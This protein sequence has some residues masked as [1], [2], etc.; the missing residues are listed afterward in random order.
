MMMFIFYSL[1]CWYRVFIGNSPNCRTNN[2]IEL[3]PQSHPSIHKHL[4]GSTMMNPRLCFCRR[5]RLQI[6]KKKNIINHRN[7]ITVAH[8]E[9]SVFDSIPNDSDL[10]DQIKAQIE[11]ATKRAE[12]KTG[13]DRLHFT[14]VKQDAFINV[15]S[16]LGGLLL[17]GLT[18][19]KSHGNP[20]D[21]IVL[22]LQLLS[23]F[24]F[25][26][27]IMSNLIF[28]L[29]VKFHHWKK[30]QP[31]QEALSKIKIKSEMMSLSWY[32]TVDKSDQASSGD[33]DHE[34][35][36]SIRD[37]QYNTTNTVD[38]VYEDRKLDFLKWT[39]DIHEI[40]ARE[41]SRDRES[42]RKWS[43]LLPFSLTF[44]GMIIFCCVVF[45]GAYVQ[46]H[47]RQ[48]AVQGALHLWIYI[49]A[50]LF[51]VI[52]CALTLLLINFYTGR[53]HDFNS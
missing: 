36:V 17:F 40:A 32:H 19:R 23:F 3:A 1:F 14:S 49:V 24:I 22:E 28:L 53:L 43:I 26:G 13:K 4:F 27:A 50:P 46:L 51:L 7:I 5:T 16:F 34:L 42:M 33:S 41:E 29:F 9:Q 6:V 25:L 37:Q 52:P 11:E 31:Y 21:R 2:A 15:N 38:S 30:Y 39:K 45:M 18:G 12:K 48:E 35:L 47:T 8:T 20:P 10:R 44:I